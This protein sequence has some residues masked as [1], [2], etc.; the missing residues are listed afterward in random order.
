MLIRDFTATQNWKGL[1]DTLSYLKRLGVNA[2][3]V[4][5]FNNFEGYSSWGYNPNFY[6]AP[7]KVY[8]TETAVK[9]FIDACHQKG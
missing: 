5:P 3:E 1:Q 4:M 7:D 9:Q 2:I 8:G 6:F